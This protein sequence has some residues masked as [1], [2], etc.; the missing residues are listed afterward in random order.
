M[1]LLQQPLQLVEGDEE[2]VPL[3]VELLQHQR[4]DEAEEERQ[5]RVQLVD[6]GEVQDEV[7]DMEAH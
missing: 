4:E 7:V 6:A 5:M 1:N 2:P 3:L